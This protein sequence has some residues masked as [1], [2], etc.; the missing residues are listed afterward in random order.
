MVNL[1]YHVVSLVAV[2]LALT[3]GI[4]MGSTVIDRVIV[5][6]LNRRVDSVRRSVTNAEAENGRLRGQLQ[7]VQDFANQARDQLVHGH[8]RGVPV[9]VVA[10]A[11]VDRKPVDGLRQALVVS[12]ATLTG[13]LWFTAKMRLE[14]EG[15]VRALAG[16]LAVAVDRPEAL[17]Q[18][19]VERVAAALE[20]SAGA[21]VLSAL[22]TAGFVNYDPPPAESAS[23]FPALSTLPSSGV[24]VVL[25]GGAGADVGDDQ[26][27]VP[28][29]RALAQS[30]GR[31]VAAESGQ[32]TPGGRDVFVGLLR[33]DSSVA[34]RLSTVDNLESA[35][36][37]AAAV[38]ALGDLAVPRLGHYG[39]G[40]GAQRLLP[41]SQT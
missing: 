20:G 31:V 26:V 37:Q 9:L 27:A 39:V 10:S 41:P 5:D 2:F 8:L 7:T 30:S 35:M 38:L 19:A 18:Q 15:D 6:D 14:N 16:A 29:A 28:L 22:A 13:T 3:V 34:S 12:Q 24:R 36:G 1:R 25:V 33:K 4:V 40:D 21:G 32:D 11:G 23:A 17:R